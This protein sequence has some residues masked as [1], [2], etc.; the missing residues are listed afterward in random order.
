MAWPK[1]APRALMFCRDNIVRYEI[2]SDGN[3]RVGRWSLQWSAG[4]LTSVSPVEE[5][6]VTSPRPLFEDI[7]DRAFRGMDSFDR[8]LAHGVP[9]WRRRLDAASGI[10]VHGHNGIAVGDID[11]DGWMRLRLPARRAAQPAV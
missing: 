6:L 10:D 7:T 3:Y 4:R 1:R 5:T 11:G 8:Q 2:A 9:Y